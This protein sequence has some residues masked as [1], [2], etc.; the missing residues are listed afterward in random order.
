MTKELNI[1]KVL[2]AGTS[3]E[4]IE[5]TYGIKARVSLDGKL[6]NLKYSQI[7]S[8]K[9]LPIVHECRGIILEMGTWDVVSRGFERFFN[10]GEEVR[11]WNKVNFNS[12]NLAVYDKV[13]GSI[14]QLFYYK[15][16]SM[17]N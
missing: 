4:E 8:D 3:F 14:I 11:N 9:H 12:S 15:G 5:E 2:R 13:D 16:E 1:Q 7:K 17:A 6:V 10:F